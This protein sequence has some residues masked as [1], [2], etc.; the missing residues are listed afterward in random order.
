MI[1]LYNRGS[2]TR[3][4]RAW[5]Q[6]DSGGKDGVWGVGGRTPPE[7]GTGVHGMREQSPRCGVVRAGRCTLASPR[8]LQNLKGDARPPPPPHPGQTFPKLPPDP[9]APLPAE[10][11]GFRPRP[12]CRFSTGCLPGTEQPAPL[13]HLELLL[14]KRP[15]VQPLPALLGLPHS[16]VGGQSQALLSSGHRAGSAAALRTGL[17]GAVG[18]V[19]GGK[20][21][22]AGL[23]T[24]R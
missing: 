6:G 22:P 11:S 23:A 16:G 24:L 1:M 9:V 12:W 21:C 19:S 17:L 4:A 8:G 13:G 10:S 5:G 20:G 14:P 15:C 2:E 18:R 3:R 7:P